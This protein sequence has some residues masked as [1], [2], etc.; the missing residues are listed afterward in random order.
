MSENSFQI[1]LY[2]EA[3]GSIVDGPGIRYG[4][5]CQGCSHNC[6]DCHNP[7]SHSYT[8]GRLVSVDEIVQNIHNAQSTRGV[9]LSGGEPFD[10]ATAMAEL[11]RRLKADGYDVWCYSGYTFEYLFEIANSE[12]ALSNSK[13]DAK[14]VK[15]LLASVDVLVDGPFVKAKKSYD[16]LYRGSTNQRLVD[17]KKSLS[18]GKFVEW[19]QEFERP[20]IP[21]AW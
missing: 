6:E 20:A 7:D 11:A 2:G 18:S 3:P 12:P 1:R 15:G 13:I 14:G 19:R 16:A 5:F 8:G 21:E 4:V 10:Q 17:V 9:T